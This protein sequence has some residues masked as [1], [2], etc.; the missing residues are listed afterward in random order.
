MITKA[1]IQ[2]AMLLRRH[3]LRDTIKE[4]I[5]WDVLVAAGGATHSIKVQCLS[6]QTAII[7]WGDNSSTEA[8]AT[9]L[10]TYSHA[11]PAGTF[12]IVITGGVFGFQGWIDAATKDRIRALRNINTMGLVSLVDCFGGQNVNALSALQEGCRISSSVKNCESVFGQMRGITAIPP[13]MGLPAGITTAYQMWL[14]C[15][16]LLFVPLSFWPVDGFTYSGTIDLRSLFSNCYV[17]NSIAPS[18]ILW[19]S[20]KSFS[21]SAGTFPQNKANS[22]LNHA[23]SYTDPATGI[24]YSKIPYAWGGAPD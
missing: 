17:E 11:Y 7:D 4:D 10:T 18:H 1:D 21:V 15:N 6:G 19:D 24:T 9:T 13:S 23:S 5:S 16:S 22:W 12:N 8:T 2:R 3:R 20:G 14:F